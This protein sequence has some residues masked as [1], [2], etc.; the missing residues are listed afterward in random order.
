M[1]DSVNPLKILPTIVEG[2]LST[3][4]DSPATRDKRVK[5][6]LEERIGGKIARE[7][8]DEDGYQMKSVIISLSCWQDPLET[9]QGAT[10]LKA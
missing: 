7:Q 6:S 8:K 10:M 9:A 2:N 4:S 3:V 5:K 1:S